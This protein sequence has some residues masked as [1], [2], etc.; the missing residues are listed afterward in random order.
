VFLDTLIGGDDTELGFPPSPPGPVGRG[1]AVT[2]GEEDRFLAWALERLGFRW[3]GFRRVRAGVQRRIRRRI[4]ELE[5]EDTSS[6]RRF[7]DDHPEEWPVLDSLCRITISRFHRGK[8][9][10]GRLGT[11]ILPELAGGVRTEEEGTLWCW[12]AGCASGEEPLSLRILWDLDLRPRFPGIEL[13][14]VAS[15]SDPALL[16]RT[17][18]ALYPASSLRDVPARWRR[19]AFEAVGTRYRVRGRHRA[20]V[21]LLTQD[22]RAALP[23]KRFHLILC[24]NLVFTYFSE[25]LQRRILGGVVER[26]RSGGVLLIGEHEHLPGAS[27]ALAPYP[28]APGFFR[29]T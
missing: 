22:I 26:L 4:R 28:G 15:D 19:E 13:R 5:L 24:R 21:E 6:Y 29:R 20:G 18:Q 9:V 23:E 7:L 27:P 14:V 1:Q 10:F 3:A 25:N 11:V 12:S 17:R 16:E 2:A 8:R